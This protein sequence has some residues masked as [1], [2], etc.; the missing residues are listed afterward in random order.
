MQKQSQSIHTKVNHK[1]KKD[2]VIAK[3][4]EAKK[5]SVALDSRRSTRVSINLDKALT[6][7]IT[8][9]TLS[10]LPWVRLQRI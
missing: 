2:S 4:R 1:S 9:K 8:V 6:L 5:H 10:R 3:D 7:P